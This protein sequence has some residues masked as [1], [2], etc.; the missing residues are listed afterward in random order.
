[1]IPAILLVV[2]VVV[3]ILAVGRVRSQ[4]SGLASDS[5]LA[6]LT[7]VALA[8]AVL[9][10]LTTAHLLFG[11]AVALAAGAGIG[12]L[13]GVPALLA[14][15]TPRAL[16]PPSPRGAPLPRALLILAV[17][18]GGIAAYVVVSRL[19]RRPDGEWDAFAFWNLRARLFQRASGDLTVV[20][21]P[22]MAGS[23]PDYPLLVSG[24]V[25]F[26]ETLLG[27]GSSAPSAVV[28]LLFGALAVAGI[29]AV[30]RPRRG[31]AVAIVAALAFLATPHVLREISWRYADIPLG[32]LLLLAV[33]WLLSAHER[34][35]GARS[36]IV[37]AGICTSLGAWTKNEGAVHV[38]AVGL[39]LIAL[40]P[41]GISRRAALGRYLMGAAPFLVVL[42]AFKLGLAPQ[43]DLVAGTDGSSALARLTDP[44]RYVEIG[45]TWFAEIARFSHWNFILPAA[46][47][48]AIGGRARGRAV[49]ATGVVVLSVAAAYAAVYVL[50]PQDLVWHLRHSID[51]LH[52]HIYPTLLVLAALRGLPR[53]PV[54]Q[55]ESEAETGPRLPVPSPPP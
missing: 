32:A 12:A 28:A 4:D 21:S 15:R 26:G 49:A 18:G 2:S 25:A 29:V 1:M 17:V 45:K 35:A 23:H 55:A 9:S 27:D 46:M 38:L 3:A 40:P 44:A 7:T 10:T 33:G 52:F 24:L 30:L 16:T 47:L 50:T 51:R 6:V 34:P 43:N 14:R 48:V 31:A 54:V 13:V 42:V 22:D 19:A 37:L 39:A 11:P 36:A 8:L 5:A 53:P 41:V 20:F